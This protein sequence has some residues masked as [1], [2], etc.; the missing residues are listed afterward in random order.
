MR[1]L[2]R[3]GVFFCLVAAGTLVYLAEEAGNSHHQGSS[4]LITADPRHASS[5][6]T[7][8]RDRGRKGQE[9]FNWKHFEARQSTL[10]SRANDLAASLGGVRTVVLSSHG[11]EQRERGMENGGLS[12]SD[13]NS[14]PTLHIGASSR[15]GKALRQKLQLLINR[16]KEAKLSRR[17]SSLKQH[18]IK[19]RQNGGAAAASAAKKHLHA[20]VEAE[21]HMMQRWSQ[22]ARSRT[23]G[24]G[25][26]VEEGVRVPEEEGRPQH[27]EGKVY[28][29]P[30]D[31]PYHAE[32][33]D[34]AMEQKK[35]V[36]LAEK[37]RH[38]HPHLSPKSEQKALDVLWR[39]EYTYHYHAFGPKKRRAKAAVS[40]TSE[41]DKEST[42]AAPKKKVPPLVY[43]P[44]GPRVACTTGEGCWD[45]EF[46]QPTVLAP[47]QGPSDFNGATAVIAHLPRL[48]SGPTQLDEYQKE[49]RGSF[50]GSSL[51]VHLVPS[52]SA[53]V[54]VS[55]SVCLCLFS[56]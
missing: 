11:K 15:R 52:A 48:G 16:L 45:H 19:D 7:L 40:P 38:E 10:A 13:A 39:H 56:A 50:Q 21:Y 53:S 23:A 12:V 8:E 26:E 51:C 35:W 20:D 24:A 18:P 4:S 36:A 5:W 27:Y 25:G 43:P 34:Q 29:D 47:P 17:D 49:V 14:I 32:P 55:V 30:Y 6:D 37:F 1:S 31:N 54:S 28:R 22:R 41:S 46:P 42:P 33:Y 2:I 3:A 9:I 44:A